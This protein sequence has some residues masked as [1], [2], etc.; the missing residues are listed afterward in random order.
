MSLKNQAFPWPTDLIQESDN[1]KVAVLG[2]I[3][4]IYIKAI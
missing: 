4:Q 3:F 2:Q 1:K